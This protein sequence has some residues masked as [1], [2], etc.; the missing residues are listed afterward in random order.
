M[1]LPKHTWCSGQ[2]YLAGLQLKGTL[3]EDAYSPN[4]SPPLLPCSVSLGLRACK[5]RIIVKGLL[6][7]TGEAGEAEGVA[8]EP[9][10]P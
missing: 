1:S 5:Q 6:T 9:A 7:D 8:M 10:A 2:A 3:P 4:P